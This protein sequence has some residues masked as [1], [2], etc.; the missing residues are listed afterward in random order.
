MGGEVYS[1]ESLALVKSSDV[2]HYET[3]QPFRI[4]LFIAYFK[5]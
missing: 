1:S 2:K 5:H 3:K 4:V